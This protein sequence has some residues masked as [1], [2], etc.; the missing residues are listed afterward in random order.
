ME[1]LAGEKVNGLTRILTNVDEFQP[2]KVEELVPE[3]NI[4]PDTYIIYPEG[5]FH[6]FYGVS[7]TLPRYQEKI[8]PY[9][10]RIKFSSKWRSEEK[11]NNSRSNSLRKNSTIE[12]VNPWWDKKYFYINL[13]T[14]ARVLINEY[15]YIL[16]NGKHSQRIKLAIISRSMHK[17]VALAWISNPGKKKNVCHINDD[18]T[19]YLIENLKWGT[20]RENMKGKTCRTDTMEQKYLDLVNKGVI[21]G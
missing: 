4:V 13:V 7:N 11:L 5:G 1:D 8:W 2:R 12:Q 17:L 9:V 20:H 16:K 10:K 14:N 15:T 3:K 21:K 6:P 18:R 19:N